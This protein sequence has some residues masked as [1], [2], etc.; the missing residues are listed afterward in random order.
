MERIAFCLRLREDQIEAY[1]RAHR[2]VCPEFV[3]AIKGAGIEQ[4]FIVRRGVYLFSLYARR[5]LQ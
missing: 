4:Y 3:K 2:D 1:D 5:G